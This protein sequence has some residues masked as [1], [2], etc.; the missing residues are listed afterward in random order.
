MIDPEASSP[1]YRGPDSPQARNHQEERTSPS[2]FAPGESASSLG[3]VAPTGRLAFRGGTYGALAP[4]ALFIAGVAWLGLSGAPDERGF[5]PVLLAAIALG[6]FLAKDARGYSEAVVRGMSRRIVMLMVLAW[7]LAGVLGSLVSAGGFVTSLVALAT[8]AGVDGG[9]FVGVAFLICALVSTATGTSLGTIIVVAPLLYPAAA[10]LE[11]SPAMLIG[12]ILAG[13]TFGDNISLVSDTTIAS[14]STQ[15][16]DIGGVVRSR[17]KYA[18]PAGAGA[19]VLYGLL[20]DAVSPAAGTTAPPG[21]SGLGGIWMLAAPGASVAMLLRKRHLVESL[22]A[23]VAAGVVAGTASGAFA[24]ETLLHVDPDGFIARGV[25]LEGMERGVG[26]SVFTILLM[27]MVAGVEASGVVNDWIGRLRGLTPSPT[28][29]EWWIFGAVSGSV[30]LTTHSVVAILSVGDFTSEVG[31]AAGLSAYR[32]ANLLDM[33][34]C[35]YPFLLPIFIPTILAASMT[36]SG[37]AFGLPHVS[38]MTVG[39]FNFHSWGLLLML[40]FAI[41]TGFGRSEGRDADPA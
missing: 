7:I 11:A 39:L 9:A 12:A 26:V 16:A 25:L 5:W 10:S 35:T 21:P 29:A 3:S 18:L 13:A 15:G 19:L 33:A 6:T 28:R 40:L 38:P 30:V 22:L 27:G 17:V 32:R 14:A 31:E 36:A 41:A 24:P 37:A 8:A 34:V 4:L 2:G 20:G 23:G 1:D